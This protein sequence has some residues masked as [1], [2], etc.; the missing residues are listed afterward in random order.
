MLYYDCVSL[1]LI[2]MVAI[3][4]QIKCDSAF[5]QFVSRTLGIANHLRPYLG[6]LEAF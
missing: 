2:K 6:S 5:W 3:Y 1:Y 4:M